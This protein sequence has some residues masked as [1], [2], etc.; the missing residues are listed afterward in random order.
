[1]GRPVVHF[2]IGCKDIE[3]AADFCA[4]LFDWKLSDGGPAATDRRRA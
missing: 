4:Q 1:M 2:E 3:K